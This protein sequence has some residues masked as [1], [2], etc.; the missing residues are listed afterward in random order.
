MAGERGPREQR[1]ATQRSHYASG[2]TA[3]AVSVASPRAGIAQWLPGHGQIS[4]W[5]L[6][7][8]C[9]YVGVREG[10]AVGLV[11]WYIMAHI[12]YVR[13]LD[14]NLYRLQYR[15]ER[16]GTTWAMPFPRTELN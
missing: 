4:R 7:G 1:Q 8:A 13:V 3:V 14:F 12:S 6:A 16:F 9:W 5:I 2:R 15:D 11:Y 10:V